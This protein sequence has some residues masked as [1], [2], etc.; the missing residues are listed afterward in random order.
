MT[1]KKSTSKD[2]SGCVLS[3]CQGPMPESPGHWQSL[4]LVHVQMLTECT[5]AQTEAFFHPDVYSLRQSPAESRLLLMLYIGNRLR[6]PVVAELVLLHQRQQGSTQPQRFSTCVC[7]CPPFISLFPQLGFYRQAMQRDKRGHLFSDITGTEERIHK[8]SR[9][10]NAPYKHREV[11]GQL[12][13]SHRARPNE[14]KGILSVQNSHQLKNWA[15]V[16]I[17]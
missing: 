14:S 4:P 17:E 13:K 5:Q 11:K 6:F 12:K 10:E 2:P 3:C 9:V 15:N 8:A 1:R 16:I 7:V